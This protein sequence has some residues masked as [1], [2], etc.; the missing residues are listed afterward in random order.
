MAG[1]VPL[2]L[3]LG[4]QVKTFHAEMF[5]KN[6]REI[7]E[8]PL[9]EVVEGFREKLGIP[10]PVKLIHTFEAPLIA[11]GIALNLT[12]Y[13][14]SIWTSEKRIELPIDWQEFPQNE[15]AYHASR[16]IALLTTHYPLL[17][18]I[19]ALVIA[20]AAAILI[21]PAFTLGASLLGI[22]A[23]ATAQTAMNAISMFRAAKIANDKLR[24]PQMIQ[25][26]IDANL[27]MRRFITREYDLDR[28]LIETVRIISQLIGHVCLKLGRIALDKSTDRLRL[29]LANRLQEN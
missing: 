10:Y 22:L 16:E 29:T 5:A 28:P 8:G 24:T 7:Q 23:G 19:A 9:K 6:G 25:A 17:S 4:W 14:A 27:R 21:N 26:G 3:F 13:G 2:S 20:V 11:R 15:L 18:R 1:I 12:S